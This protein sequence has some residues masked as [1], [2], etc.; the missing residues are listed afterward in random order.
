MEEQRSVVLLDLHYILL[1][2]QINL[3]FR[4]AKCHRMIGSHSHTAAADAGLVGDTF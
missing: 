1:R 3:A 4:E 2:W